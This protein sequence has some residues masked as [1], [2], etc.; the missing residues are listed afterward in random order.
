MILTT[1][2]WCSGGGMERLAYV[3][4][5]AEKHSTTTLAGMAR[6]SS[7]CSEATGQPLKKWRVG[8]ISQAA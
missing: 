2:L 4:R 8:N 6:T 1:K 7:L 5:S 3:A